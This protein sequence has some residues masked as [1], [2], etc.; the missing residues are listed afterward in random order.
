M[1]RALVAAFLAAVAVAAV[2]LMIFQRVFLAP[3]PPAHTQ[4]AAVATTAAPTPHAAIPTPDGG[5]IP[6]SPTS[7]LVLAHAHGAVERR[8]DGAGSW[9]LVAPG[10]ALNARQTL[11]TAAR[12]RAVI[13]GSGVSVVL[14]GRTR[15]RLEDAHPG[16]VVLQLEEGRAQASVDG[17]AQT[18]LQ[19]RVRGSDA[20]VTTAGGEFSILADGQGM[21]AVAA[22]SPGVRLKARG[23]Q[24]DVPPGGQRLVYP[25][26][27]PTAPQPVPNSLLLKVTAPRRAVQREMQ[28]TVTGVATPGSVVTV[29]GRK[30][31]TR[32][33]GHF[34][35]RVPLGTGPNVVAVSAMDV[36]GRRQAQEVH[37]TV[38]RHAPDIKGQMQW[39]APRGDRGGQ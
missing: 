9:E 28:T 25:D 4:P 6:P 16:G 15:L 7:N 3:K 22:A 37:I 33:D 8:Q 5:G 21:V 23:Q 18:V 11:R 34:R 27:P 38:D 39:G 30:T 26:R 29:A 32:A 19:M 24:V 12:G 35:L 17:G 31:Q 13:S 14:D 2:G 36:T 1:T 20:E 10:A